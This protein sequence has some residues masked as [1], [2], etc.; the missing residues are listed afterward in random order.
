MADS[1]IRIGVDLGGTK[2]EA[3]ALDPAG[4][5][6]ARRRVPTPRS[7]YPDTI[8]AI[9]SLVAD[10]E[11]DA[12]ATAPA[13]GIGTP[14]SLSPTTGVI[15][16]ANSTRLNGQRLDQDLAERLG[17]PVR[18][19]NDANCFA[20]AEAVSGAGRGTGTVFGV[21][22]GT[23]VGGGIVTDGKL[24]LGANRISGEWGHNP[25]PNPRIEELPGPA[26]Y[27][28]RHGCIET[29]CS[30]PGLARDHQTETGMQASPEEIVMLAAAGDMAARDSLDRHLVRLARAMATVVNLLDPDAIVLGGGLSNM[31]HL[32]TGL[33][34]AMKP[35]VFSDTFSTPV[36]RIELGDSAGVIGAAWLWT[37]EEM[38]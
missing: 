15:R 34:P 33:A 24:L 38:A 2:I 3:A 27:C 35:H 11:M 6:I 36:L 10:L 30:G 22:L 1:P 26:C 8:D 37:P 17:R 14:G 32:V 13:L 16:N 29:W 9:A 20:L 4:T 25:L 28:G 18:L 19:A 23:G 7:K 31:D 12:G 5:V 21:I